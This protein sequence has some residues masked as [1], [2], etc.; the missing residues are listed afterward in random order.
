MKKISINIMRIYFLGIFR[1]LIKV[2]SR[3]FMQTL[4]VNDL[5]LIALYRLNN[6]VEKEKNLINEAIKKLQ[7]KV[8]E[9][10]LQ[11]SPSIN[12]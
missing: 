11:K 7:S 9:N 6:D 4:T 3:A 8:S 12:S 1:D 2:I 5:L 10:D